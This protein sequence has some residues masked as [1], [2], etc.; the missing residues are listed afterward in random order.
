M[1]IEQKEHESTQDMM[2]ISDI[3]ESIQE[4]E[5]SLSPKRQ[6]NKNNNI[7]KPLSPPTNRPNYFKNASNDYISLQNRMEIGSISQLFFR[8]SIM[9]NELNNFYNCLKEKKYS[10][11]SILPIFDSSPSTDKKIN[12]FKLHDTYLFSFSGSKDGFIGITNF[13]QFPYQTIAVKCHNGKITDIHTTH[14]RPL[15]LYTSA[16]D[17]FVKVLDLTRIP[18]FQTLQIDAN[19]IDYFNENNMYFGDCIINNQGSMIHGFDIKNGGREIYAVDNDGMLIYSDLRTHKTFTYPIAEKKIATIRINPYNN[20]YFAI[21]ENRRKSL[22]L[23]DFRMIKINNN[24]QCIHQ[25][26]FK[27]AQKNINFSHDGSRLLTCGRDDF[28]RVYENP[29]NTFNRQY[30]QIKHS[31][32]TGIWICDFK[33]EFHPRY[34]QIVLT[35]NLERKG[36]DILYFGSNGQIK[37]HNVNDLSK[38]KGVHTFGQFHPR[39]DDYL[40]GVTYDKIVMYYRIRD[41]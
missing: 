15:H 3:T 22:Q 12:A 7:Y 1:I 16:Q 30:L 6:I 13:T 29:L 24:I 18:T 10:L 5:Q 8:Q 27:N 35:G 26:K 2:D 38:T 40:F 33:P 34:P 41:I 28:I 32:N 11:Q 23:F 20:N 17:G 4:I 36:I 31:N 37:Q 21:T 39:F 14:K 19:E 25:R 9:E